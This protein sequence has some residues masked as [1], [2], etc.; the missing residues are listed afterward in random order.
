MPSWE[1]L[2][3]Y[4]SRHGKFIRHGSNH[5]IYNY[6]GTRIRV[7]RGSGEISHNKWR[8][9]LKHQLQITQE[10]FNAGL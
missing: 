8:E 1:D 7:S 10:E 6:G 3:R 9:I 5:D 4:L 2:R